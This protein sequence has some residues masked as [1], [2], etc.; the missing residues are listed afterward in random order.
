[1]FYTSAGT[2]I[3]PGGRPVPERLCKTIFRGEAAAFVICWLATLWVFQSR[4]F[5]DPGALWHV[6]VGE[7]ILDTGYFPRTDPFTFPFEGKAWFPQHWGGEVLMALAD[8]AAGLDGMLF[9]F[10][11]LI[12]VF[13]TWIFARLRSGGMKVP[14]AFIGTALAYVAAAFHFFARPHLATI[15]MVGLTMAWIIDVDRGRAGLGRLALLIPLYVIW[16]NVHGGTLGGCMMLGLA[17]VGWGIGFLRNGDSPLKSWRQVG[18][19]TLILAGCGLSVLVNPFGLDLLRTWHRILG[20][21][22][23]KEIVSE[24][25]PL[26]LD[27][28]AGQVVIGFAAVYL[29]AL[30]GTLPNWPRVTWLIPLVWF[31]LTLKGIRQ[32]PLFVVSAAFALADLWPHT[33]WHRILLKNGD[34]LV[35]NPTRRSGLVWVLS[36][37]L[38]VTGSILLILSKTSVP[39]IGANWARLDAA[40]VP[41]DLNPAIREYVHSVPPGTRIFNDCNWGGYLIWHAPEL[42]IF[43]DDRFELCGDDWLYAYADA[44]NFHPERIDA[45]ADE[46][47][48]RAAVVTV[49]TEDEPSAAE[50]YLTESKRW[51]LVARGKA[52]AFFVRVP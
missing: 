34:N 20:S 48:F 7:I 47:G 36:P 27:S 5:V 32:G 15:G 38:L 21:T 45:W 41:V 23:M 39:L 22:A 46:Y 25:M 11:T 42:K 8:K 10:A 31:V 18:L 13:F 29:F 40:A 6:K 44:I 17:S 9:G 4:A 37:L 1:V 49:G 19:L 50:K 3:S 26:S 33:A 35:E 28:T 51:K 30:V 12:A 2:D 24:H 16:T 14:L 52:A 43:M